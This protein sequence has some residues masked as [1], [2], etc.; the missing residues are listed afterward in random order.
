M[1]YNIKKKQESN[2]IRVWQ[3]S[4]CH[5]TYMSVCNSINISI[6]FTAWKWGPWCERITTWWPWLLLLTCSLRGTFWCR[7]NSW[8]WNM[9]LMVTGCSLRG[10]HCSIR[11]SCA[12]TVWYNRIKWDSRLAWSEN[13]ENS[14]KVTVEQ[15]VSIMAAC[16]MTGYWVR[17]RTSVCNM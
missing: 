7:Q 4:G 1:T 16:H 6:Y 3:K 2:L 10:V 5:L 8:A 9:S 14:L 13:K 17:G 12:T 15:R 11:N